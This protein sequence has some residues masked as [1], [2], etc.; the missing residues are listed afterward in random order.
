MNENMLSWQLEHVQSCGPVLQGWNWKQTIIYR[1]SRFFLWKMWLYN[2]CNTRQKLFHI[3]SI[4]IYQV[5]P[6]IKL[7]Q[8]KRIKYVCDFILRQSFC[9]MFNPFNSLST[10]FPNTP[11]SLSSFFPFI[12]VSVNFWR[13][14]LFEE[15]ASAIFCPMFK[16]LF[17][18]HFGCPVAWEINDG[19]SAMLT[20]AVSGSSDTGDK[21]LLLF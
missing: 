1:T 3:Y 7:F 10:Y 6:V 12:N 5:K 8:C 4:D 9:H 16:A 18:T 17:F 19:F 21:L 14:S 13:I 20:L 2:E 11:S 15:G